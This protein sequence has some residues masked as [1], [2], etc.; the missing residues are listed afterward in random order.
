MPT[1]TPILGLQVAV[2]TDQEPTYLITNLAASLTTLDTLF[3]EVTGHDHSGPGQ[4]GAVVA[5]APTTASEEFTPAA[6]ATTVTLSQTPLAVLLVSRDGVIQSAGPG[7]YS[8]AAAVV[9]FTQAF[10]GTERVIV[11]FTY[12]A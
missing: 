1:N 4:G 11:L 10:L 3:S 5:T 12:Q 8:V 6:A 2:A 9:T 7:H